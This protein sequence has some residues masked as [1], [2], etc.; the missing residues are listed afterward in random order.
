MKDFNI[1]VIGGGPA[2][3]IAALTAADMGL[4]VLLAERS[5]VIGN[6][7]RC[8]EG[9]DEKGLSEFFKPDPSWVASEITGYSLVA[10][11]GTS[12]DINIGDNKGF[13]LER[14][15][16]DR[17]IAE[18]AAAKGAAIM[19]GVEAVGMSDYNNSYRTVSLRND[20]REWNLKAGIIVAADGVES[21]A[22]RWAGLKTN[23]ILH[24]M[25]TGTQ[26][27]LAG[28]DV[29]P[30]VFKMYF[31]GEYAPGGYAW[32]FPKG[33]NTANVGLGISGDYA[34]KKSPK[35]YLDEFLA[36]Y[37]PNSAIVGRT[38]GGVSCTGGI[39]KI[40]T[41]GV[42]VAG[43]AAHMANPITGGGIINAMIAGKLAAETAC[44]ALKKGKTGESALKVYAKRCDKRIGKMNRRFYRLKEGIFSIPDDRLNEIARE[45]ISLPEEKRT[46]V[47]ILKS[48]LFKQPSLLRVLA[49]VTL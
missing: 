19:T 23:T 21:R 3:T 22:A 35:K 24:D 32:V 37:F 18:K 10:P 5:N 33:S 30:H 28:I 1:V 48:A 26:V 46:P 25:E 16:F 13:I 49:K 41:D 2:G 4:S 9:V 20:E 7:V 47:R 44:E 29:D 34:K 36:Y 11:D 45:I 27:T 31:T 39:E 38:F 12:V 40:F 6:P 43:D 17:M 8:A 15:I 42:M 14:Q